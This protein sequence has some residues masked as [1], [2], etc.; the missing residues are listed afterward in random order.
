VNR[1]ELQKLGLI[2]EREVLQAKA[3]EMGIGFVDLDRVRI[4]PNAIQAADRELATE[5]CAI[6]VKLDMPTLYVAMS[7]PHNMAAI[8][9]FKQRTGFRIVPVLALAKEIES[10]IDRY[11]P[12]A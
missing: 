1:E 6:P 7:N 5:H 8:D 11:Y 2:G 10:A 3:I 4:Q 9:G 12:E